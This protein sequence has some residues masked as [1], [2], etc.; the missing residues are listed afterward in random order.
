MLYGG[1]KVASVLVPV[2]RIEGKF[3]FAHGC[4]REYAESIVFYKVRN[5]EI[6]ES[7]YW[8]LLES[9]G[10]YWNLMEYIGIYSRILLNLLESTCIISIVLYKGED[11]EYARVEELNG[12]VYRWR[13]EFIAKG[14]CVPNQNVN[15]LDSQGG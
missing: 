1:S 15:S 4:V 2:L 9:N 5:L 10:I 12:A 3:R 7:L 14:V 11:T 8:N 6:I 13:L